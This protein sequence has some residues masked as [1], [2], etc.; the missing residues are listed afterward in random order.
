M[1]KLLII[2]LLL[3]C[4]LLSCDQSFSPTPQAKIPVSQP[5]LSQNEEVVDIKMRKY[6]TQL[7]FQHADFQQKNLSENQKK[8][9]KTW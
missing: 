1:L 7:V 4:F 8:E 9:L 6:A 2:G 5:F 3:G